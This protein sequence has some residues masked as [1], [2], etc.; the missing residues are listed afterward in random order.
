[1]TVAGNL[2]ILYVNGVEVGRNA[3]LTLTPMSLGA[4]TQNW[5]GRSQY[6]GSLS[7]RTRG[8]LPHLRQCPR[9]K[10][11]ARFVQRHRRRTGWAL[12]EP[13]HR[14]CRPPRELGLAR[15]RHLCDRLRRRHLGRVGR[16]P[17]RLA[18]LD[19]RRHADRA[20]QRRLR[21]RCLDQGGPHVS[22]EFE[23]QCPQRLHRRHSGQRHQLSIPLQHG[24]RHHLQQYQSASPPRIG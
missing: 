7:Q 11:R 17:L 5:I 14:L 23:R 10:R 9:G 12:G 1:M 24:W 22:R 21:N 19:R 8:R 13:G 20:R 16:I 6:S 4:T 3:A 2:G 15:R 18:H